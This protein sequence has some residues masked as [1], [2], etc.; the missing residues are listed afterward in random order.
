[1]RR[2]VRVTLLATGAVALALLIAAAL[3]GVPAVWYLGSGT[4][5]CRNRPLSEHPSPDGALKVVVFERDCGA[6]T[7]FTTQATLIPASAGLP[8]AGG[9]LFVADP[10]KAPR[11]AWGGPSLD[12]QWLGPRRVALFHD[13]T[14]GVSLA[15]T[16]LGDVSIVYNPKW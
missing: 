12:V 10:G 3:V 9:N 8:E 7:D 14:A 15:E 13:G 11:A 1:M 6:T 2:S 16:Q 5:M 4:S